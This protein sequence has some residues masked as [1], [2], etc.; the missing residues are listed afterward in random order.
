MNNA[1]R[2]LTAALPLVLLI[3]ACSGSPGESVTPS[4]TEPAV[5]PSGTSVSEVL[6]LGDSVAVGQS[7]PLATALQEVGVD[8]TSL[9]SEGG[10]NVVGPFSE[11]N[12]KTL[13]DEIGSASPDVVIYQLTTYDW[14]TREEQ[15][16]GYGRLLETVAGEGADLVFV[17]S[18]PIRPDDFYEP[19]MGDLERASEVA[20]EVA[21]GSSGQATV[22]DATDVWGEE[23]LQ[24]RE[25]TPDRNP[26]GIHTCPQG[27]ARFTAWLLVELAELYP[28]F[29]TP[30]PEAWAEGDWMED[31]HFSAC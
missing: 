9:A 18:P 24:E 29:T 19:H 22:L 1:L 28:G 31:H 16:D 30:E 21:E 25:G 8:F 26:D 5:A 20:R 17:T 3:A 15:L 13:P 12:W 14:G 27:A 4:A 7:L 23:Y 2:A 6:L 11:E 10:G